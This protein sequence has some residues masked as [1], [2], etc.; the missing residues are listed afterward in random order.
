MITIRFG[1]NNED[2]RPASDFTTVRQVLSNASLRTQLGFGDNTEARVNGTT[3]GAGYALRDNDVV[4][5][6][7]KANTKG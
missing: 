7:T 2:T 1:V 4:D 5:L 3:V 6:V